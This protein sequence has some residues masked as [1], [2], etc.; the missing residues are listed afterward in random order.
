MKKYKIKYILMYK[1]TFISF[2]K[3][4]DNKDVIFIVGDNPT[5]TFNENVTVYTYSTLN[6]NSINYYVKFLY[7]VLYKLLHNNKFNNKFN[8][9]DV[10]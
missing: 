1:D 5:V 4:N 8:S 7:N 3:L 6:N 9:K 10:V 2:K